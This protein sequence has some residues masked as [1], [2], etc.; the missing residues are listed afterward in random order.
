M[1]AVN[2]MLMAKILFADG[3]FVQNS[4][5]DFVGL[6]IIRFGFVVEQNTVV[7]HI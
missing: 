3:Y 2:P 6:Y 1:P 5:D 7:H 4:L